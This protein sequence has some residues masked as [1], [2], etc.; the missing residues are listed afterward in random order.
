MEADYDGNFP[1]LLFCC[2]FAPAIL[3]HLEFLYTP[4]K[5]KHGSGAAG[6]FPNNSG[7]DQNLQCFSG[8]WNR[9]FQGNFIAENHIVI[10][11]YLA[12]S[13]IDPN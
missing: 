3:Y 12:R 13:C 6:K 9:H 10:G 7:I 5:Q 11:N 2:S 4:S 8:G 1:K